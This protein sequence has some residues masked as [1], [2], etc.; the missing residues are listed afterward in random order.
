L[1]K[2]SEYKYASGT[3]T[4]SG[5]LSWIRSALRSR[6]LRW[7]PR[8]ESLKA[9]QV[10]YIGDNLRR[11]F[12]YKCALCLKLFSAKDVEV[13][14]YPHD[15][16]AIRS[17]EDI[18]AFVGRLFCETSNLRVVCK[19]CHAAHTYSV[20]NGVSFKD[21]EVEKRAIEFMK[22]EKQEVLDYCGSF[23]Y[24]SHSLTNAKKRREAL[25]EIF[26]KE[27]V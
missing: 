14:H 3:L 11:K 2:P 22:K 10:P 18:G 1:K 26:T 5:Y 20:K 9:A 17:L 19:P 13:D 27:A 25:V 15:A 24:N 8:A 21:A 12:S 6:W 23:G 4:E 7:P 16:G